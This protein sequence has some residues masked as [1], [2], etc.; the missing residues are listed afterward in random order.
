MLMVEDLAF[1][2]ANSDK[3][4][5]AGVSLSVKKGEILGLLGPN[6]AGKTTLISHVSGLLKIQKGS[7]TADGMALEKKRRQ[8]P[9]RIT[10]AP[11]EYAL[12]PVLTVAE[13]LACFASASGLRGKLKRERIEECVEFTQLNS[14]YQVRA[15]HLSGGLK[16]R[17]NLA[18]ALLARPDYLLLDEPTVGVDPQSRSFILD[19]VRS[20]ADQG[21]GIIYT[22]HYMEEIEA[23]AQQVVIIDHGKVLVSGTL[24][25]LLHAEA[26]RI[27]VSLQTPQASEQVMPILQQWGDVVRVGDGYQVILH[28]RVSPTELWTALSQQQIEV[29]Q[30]QFGRRNLEQL[31]MSLTHRTLR[32]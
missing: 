1:Q 5:L 32:D 16:R 27:L 10:I 26:E 29:S 2:Y 3:P 15:E 21:M 24:D 19:R 30:A 20:L 31:F 18:I 13:N 8:D 7:I 28:E 11:Q 14:H 6:G 23:L 17:L 9:T 25:E 22:S 12:Y 4:S